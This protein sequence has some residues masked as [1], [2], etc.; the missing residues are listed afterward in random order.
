[1][2]SPSGIQRDQHGVFWATLEGDDAKS[3]RECYPGRSLPRRKAESLKEAIKL[4]RLLIDDL[5]TGRDPNAENPTIVVWVQTCI[6]RKRKIAPSTKTRYLQSLR[7]QIEPHRIG[8]LRLR[9]V[10]RKQVE[11]WVDALIVQK[12]QGDDDQ[13]LDAYSIR[14]ALPCCAWRLIWRSLTA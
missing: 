2:C 11:E 14:N 6:D 10:Q 9:Q 12:K 4:Q 8:R 1:V 13:T 5:K 3:W 7:W